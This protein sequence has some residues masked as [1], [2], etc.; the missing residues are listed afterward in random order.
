[1]AYFL[2]NDIDICNVDISLKWSWKNLKKFFK[3]KNTNMCGPKKI[4]T[5]FWKATV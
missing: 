4:K 3:S 5:K 2:L 1:M